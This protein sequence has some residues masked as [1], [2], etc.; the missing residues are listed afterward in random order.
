MAHKHVCFALFNCCYFHF[1][2]LEIFVGYAHL[3]NLC[4]YVIFGM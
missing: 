4:G 3:K 2:F 1:F